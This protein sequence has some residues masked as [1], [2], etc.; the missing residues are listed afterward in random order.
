MGK[1]VFQGVAIIGLVAILAK[2]LSFIQ[3]QVIAS[4]FGTGP[5]ADAYTV[6]FNSIVYTLSIIPLK[7]LAPVLPLFTERR[8]KCGD[9]EAW[10]F[11]STV[12][13]LLTIVMGLAVAAGML[14]APHL[15]RGAASFKSETTA[16]LAVHLVRVMLPAALFF[17]L[18]HLF[19]L[20]MHS[21]KRFAL[22]AL[23]EVANRVAV[24]VLLVLLYRV[25]GIN[26]LAIGIVGGAA[27][28]FLLQV[29]GLRK[30]VRWFRFKPDWSDPTLRS[31]LVLIPPVLVSILIAQ[32]RTVL[33][34]RFASQMGEGYPSSLGY[35]KGI[36]DTIVN[37]VPFTIGVVLYP[38]F[39]DLHAREDKARLTDSLMGA[40]R[41]MALFFV[42]IS[43]VLIV[44]RVPV[45]RLIFEYG[46]FTSDSVKF[47]TGPVLYYALGLTSF[48]I[49][50][51][52]MRFYFSI[53]DTLTPAIVGVV[54]V[55]VH[56]GVVLTLRGA[57][58]H[59][60]IALAATVSKSLKVVAL[61]LLLRSRVA[62]LHLRA[63]GIFCAKL[64]AAAAGMA[65]VMYGAYR[66][67]L[68]WASV[69]AG[70]GKVLKA[71]F[72]C[73]HIGACTALGLIAFVG[74]AL[75]LQMDE[76]RLVLA[77]LRRGRSRSHVAM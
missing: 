52:L 45:V 14:A 54:C 34:F 64:L 6:A 30:E 74:L 33:D 21:H 47:T 61:F 24:I 76:V 37:M 66:L 55:F 60:S 22:P 53:K 69:P 57:M 19:T 46:K 48:A 32:A 67:L 35:A 50:I 75:M 58:M 31:L 27:A 8:E 23:G 49:E 56:V 2:A 25:L 38:F 77:A 16:A 59:E 73:G 15:V 43:V 9:Q 36:T 1:K 20:L 72:L 12:T 71:G 4:R 68:L 40:M 41:A 3:K 7:I 44:L 29:F 11:A 65:G 5:E 62:G 28:A 13:L 63:N 17:G 39:A 42:P 70:A 18:Y 26:G 10:R 51:V